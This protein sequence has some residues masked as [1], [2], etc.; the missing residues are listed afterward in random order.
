MLSN[1]ILRSSCI[2]NI[3][4]N[5]GEIHMLKILD[6]N[7]SD[8]LVVAIKRKRVRIKGNKVELKGRSYR[9]Y[10]RETRQEELV[11][12]D[13][14]AFFETRDPSISFNRLSNDPVDVNKVAHHPYAFWY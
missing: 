3:F 9:N 14:D 11:I 2:D 13:W 5:S 8:Y 7:I 12:C 10:V 1:R 4:T 6:W